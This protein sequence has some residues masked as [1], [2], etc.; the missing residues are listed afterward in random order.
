MQKAMRRIE[1]RVQREHMVAVTGNA[2][3]DSDEDMEEPDVEVADGDVAQLDEDG[4]EDN[5]KEDG[6]EEQEYEQSKGPKNQ[7]DLNDDFIDDSEACSLPQKLSLTGVE[8]SSVVMQ[9][10]S[11]PMSVVIG[12]C[13]QFIE[14]IQMR[15]ERK[16]KHDGFFVNSGA[17]ERIGDRVPVV[18]AARARNKKKRNLPADGEEAP[19]GEQAAK[20][21]KAPSKG[22]KKASKMV[23]NFLIYITANLN[24]LQHDAPHSCTSRAFSASSD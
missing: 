16:L 21:A 19:A 12:K 13:L 24:C 22:T 11:G 14:A 8:C 17:V 20:P 5:D 15:D 6:E 3:A 18:A 9:N 2:E 23:C 10:L 4:K 7:Y 1:R